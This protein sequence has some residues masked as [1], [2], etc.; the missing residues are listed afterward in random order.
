MKKVGVKLRWH[1]YMLKEF[2][3]IKHYFKKM[4]YYIYFS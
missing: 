4:R 3:L 1:V 2:K